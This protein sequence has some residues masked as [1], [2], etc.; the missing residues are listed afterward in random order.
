MNFENGPTALPREEVVDFLPDAVLI[1]D[2]NGTV[3]RANLAAAALLGHERHAVEGRGV[4]DFLPSFDW[5]LTL[6][7]AEAGPPGTAPT[8][9]L[10]TTARTGDGG[11]FTAEIHTLRL[12]RHVLH[13]HIPYGSSLVISLRDATADEE[14]RA[15][16]SRALL[17][18]E[19]VLRTAGEALIG[20][21]AEGRI[22]LVNPAAARL[23]GGKA[24]ELGGRPLLERLAPLG[25]DGEPLDPESTAL[26]RALRAGRTSRLPG[27]ELMTRDGTRLT[28]DVAVR[29]VTE[30]DRVVGAVVALTDRRPYERLADEYIA[31]QTRS[32]RH[33]EAE[34]ALHRRRTDRAV[35][36][37]H[38]LADF[39]SGPLAEALHHLHAELSRLAGDSSRPLWPE[40]TAVI[41]A[42]AADLRM[43]MALVNG[44]SLPYRHDDAPVGPQRRTVL[45]DEVVQ[46]GV[47]AATAFAGPAPVRFSVHAPRFAVHVD[48]DDMTTAVGRLI[49]DVIHSGDAPAPTG[50]H[51]VVV[52]ALQQRGLLRIEVRG[53][54]SGGVREHADIVRGIA[55]AH[56]GTLRT[57]RAPGVSGSTYVLEL[58]SAVRD[59]TGTP[60]G[61]TPA[62]ADT[63]A[64]AEAEVDADAG[65][66]VLRPTGRHRALTA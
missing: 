63:D 35:A 38:D 39:L 49:A 33:H 25:H 45:I 58:P 46:A 41:E 18:A 43:T 53:P 57:H 28:A 36:H 12:D 14:T 23:L 52:A 16:L 47:R 13:D 11:S 34:L 17:Q 7:P 65:A 54:Y 6:P 3:V 5:N 44:R 60:A 1:V 22:D 62:H 29:P 9:R 27:Q 2:D 4:L 26:T 8:A 56:G 37:A 31:A 40:A 55:E 61:G 20:T 19:A 64:E 51:H 59:D 30:G 48:P 21:D 50:P 10:R 42:L 32:V 15:L 66:A 24:S